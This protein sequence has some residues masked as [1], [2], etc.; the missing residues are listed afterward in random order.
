[1][2]LG[3]PQQGGNYYG[4]AVLW[5]GLILIALNM[6]ANG[7]WSDLWSIITTKSSTSAPH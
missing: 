7:G 1:M 6:Y 2:A 3:D 5:M 4:K